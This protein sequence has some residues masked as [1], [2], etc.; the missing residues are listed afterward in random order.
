MDLLRIKKERGIKEWQK[1]E[2]HHAYIMCVLDYVLR[3]EKRIT[4]I[5]ARSVVN[6][7]QESG[8]VT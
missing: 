2:K 7:N 3:A 8:Y 4:L 6:K 5:T 1:I